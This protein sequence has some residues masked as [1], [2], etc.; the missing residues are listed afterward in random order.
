MHMNFVMSV[1][2]ILA[3]NLGLQ[4]SP[5]TAADMIPKDHDWRNKT[6]ISSIL[7]EGVV[8]KPWRKKSVVLEEPGNDEASLAESKVADESGKSAADKLAEQSGELESILVE[9]ENQNH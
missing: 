2:N 8:Q 5:N 6:Y 7:D 3:V 9:L 1:A 4:P